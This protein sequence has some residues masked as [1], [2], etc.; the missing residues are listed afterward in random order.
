[1]GEVYLAE[2]SRLSRRVALKLLPYHFIGEE[3]RVRRF[4]QEA[5]AVGRLNHPNILIVHDTGTHEGAPYLVSELLEGKT[6]RE[7]LS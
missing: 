6:L 3:E 5:R 4:E 7:R 2:D 1:M